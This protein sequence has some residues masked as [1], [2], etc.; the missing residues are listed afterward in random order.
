MVYCVL[1]HVRIIKLFIHSEVS[2]DTAA[3]HGFYCDL[4]EHHKPCLH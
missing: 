1:T 4:A 3:V 2:S